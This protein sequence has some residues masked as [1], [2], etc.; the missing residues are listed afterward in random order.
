MTSPVV[1][2][3]T[4]LAGYTLARE[5]R[6]RD[7]T[8]SLCLI[9]HDD[10]A[11]YSKP[12]LSNALGKHK[13]PDD[14]ATAGA[15]KMR[16]DLEAEILTHTEVE[17]IYPAERQLLLADGSRRDYE[18][19]VLAVGA[20]TISPGL[21][22]DAAGRVLC[23]NSLED[24]R[25]FRRQLAGKKRVAIIGPG[26]IGCEFAN[27]LIGDDYEVHVIG[28]DTWPLGRLLPAKTGASLQQALQAV[29]VRWHLQCVVQG[30]ESAGEQVQLQLDNGQRLVVDLVLSA[31]GLQPNTGLA[32]N[33]G[34][35]TR[36]GIVVDRMLKTSDPWIYALGDCVEV[37]GRVL[38]FVMPLM[39]QAR[40]LAA[41]LSGTATAV[42]YPPM[43]VLVKTT[44][45]P[46]VVSPPPQ[47]AQ[48]EWEES[49]VEGG[50]KALFW[51]GD[52]LLGFALCGT[53]VSEKQSLTKLLPMMMD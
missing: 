41:S 7:S 18:R 31:I 42:S 46:V 13:T 34:L 14:L 39:Q 26:L 35:E 22:G 10:G 43:P 36:R 45:Y 17:A 47:G 49:I 44:R 38:P 29:G 15:D 25:G 27:D 50:A 1:I 19:L 16:A 3:G 11:F 12:M 4:G 2:V 30:I 24:Y 5:L 51:S 23:V 48:G 6:K 21:Q 28:P 40:A 32:E 8:V 33:A 9:T 20:H 37:E 52:K 53:A